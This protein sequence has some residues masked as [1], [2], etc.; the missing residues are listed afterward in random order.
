MIAIP[1]NDYIH[2]EFMNCLTRLVMRLK[3]DGIDFNVAI[4]GGTLV[5]VARDRLA[6]RAITEG[7]SHI[8]WLDSDMIFT[9]DIVDDLSF[10][11]K[12]FVSAI[13]HARREPHVSCLF[14]ELLPG[15]S[16]FD[17]YPTDTFEI[18]GCGL[19]CVYMD[20]DILRAVK[21]K[22]DTCFFPTQ[23]LGEDLAFCKRVAECGFKLY[24][25]P[26]KLGHIGHIKIYPDDKE[27]YYNEVQHGTD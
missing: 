13:Y 19:G 4:Q 27:R 23:K 5:Y 25:E 8:L 17:E 12:S 10:S 15:I 2:Y 21:D 16:Y 3:D 18:A 11:G 22:Y 24:A 9:P 26:I 6:D 20:V 1:C 7:Y 14:K